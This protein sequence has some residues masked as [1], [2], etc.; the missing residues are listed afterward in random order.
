M[1]QQVG[2]RRGE[3]RRVLGASGHHQRGLLRRKAAIAQVGHHRAQPRCVRDAERRSQAALAKGREDLA[4][5]RR[6]EL[7]AQRHGA[8]RPADRSVVERNQPTPDLQGVRRRHRLDRG[9]LQALDVGAIHAHPALRLRSGRSSR[10]SL[11]RSD[12]IRP[13][14]SGSSLL[15]PCPA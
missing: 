12:R 4:E 11:P 13:A 1:L 15:T 14:C 7:V 2:E 9:A 5:S 8:P 10:R 6:I 3:R